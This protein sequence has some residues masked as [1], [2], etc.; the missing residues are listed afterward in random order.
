LKAIVAEI[1]A[2]PNAYVEEIFVDQG[3]GVVRRTL[4]LKGEKKRENE[5]QFGKEQEAKTLDGRAIKVSHHI[6]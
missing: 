1:K 6:G 2:D 5:V 4:W 3:A